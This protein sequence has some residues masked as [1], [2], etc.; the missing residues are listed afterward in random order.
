MLLKK[1]KRLLNVDVIDRA[2]YEEYKRA[3]HMNKGRKKCSKCGW[4]DC[5]CQKTLSK[6]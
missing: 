3:F 5:E 2:G 6:W 4:F 1:L